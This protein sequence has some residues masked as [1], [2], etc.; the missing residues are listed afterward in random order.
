MNSNDV[1]KPY[2]TV[3]TIVE[4]EGRFLMVRELING[5]EML[6]Q[7]AGHVEPHETIEQAAIRETLEETGYQFSPTGLVGI[8]RFLPD[9]EDQ[10]TYLRF[11]FCGQASEQI[12]HDLDDGIIG[13]EWMTLDEIRSTQ[14]RHRTPMVLQCVLDYLEKPPYPLQVFSEAFA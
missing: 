1:W 7:P 3:A 11:S 8:Y 5:K 4:C 12:T 6:N 2:V 14:D 10:R 13:P 9:P